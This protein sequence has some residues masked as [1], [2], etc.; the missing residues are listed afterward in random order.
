MEHA[1]KLDKQNI[2]DIL[3][4]TPLQEGMLFHYLSDPES[5]QYFEQLSLCLAGRIDRGLFRKAWDVV[6]GHNEM[7]RTVFRWEK[8]S[9][10]VQIV[11]KT[12]QIPLQELDFTTEDPVRIP[13]MLA[14]FREEDRRVKLDLAVAP[15]RLALCRLGAER[16][17]LLISSHHILYDGWSTG[18]ILKEFYNAY[19]EL[20]AQRPATRP[21]KCKFKTFLKKVQGQAPERQAEFWEKYLRGFNTRTALPAERIRNREISSVQKYA[22]TV[23][24]ELA[25]RIEPAAKE[26]GAT[27]ATVL[28]LAWGILLQRYNDIDDVVFG[29]TVALRDTSIPD[30]G[31]L[32]GLLINTPP[33]RVKSDPG[34]TI[35]CALQKLNRELQERSDF[36][37]TPLTLIKQ[38]TELSKQENLFDSIVVLDN[39]PLD[40]IF[41]RMDGEFK[42][43]SYSVFE[44][45]NFDL[46]LQIFCFGPLEICFN[47]NSDLFSVER[48]QRMGEHLQRALAA[49]CET[50]SALITGIEILSETE[51]HLLLYTFNDTRVEYP[52][53]RLIHQWVEIQAEAYPDRTAV[54]FEGQSLTYRALNAKANQVAALLKEH[55]IRPGEMVGLALPRSVE[56]IA[57][58][59]GILKANGICIPID[60]EH[61]QERIRTILEDCQAKAVLQLAGARALPG[62]AGAVL[63]FDLQSLGHYPEANQENHIQPESLAY[64][65]YTSG[66]TGKPKGAM[67]HHFGIVNHALTKIGVLGIT[68]RDTVGN[69][70][71]INVIAAIWQVLAPLFTGGKLVVYPEAVEK[72]PY[73]QFQR[74]AADQVSIIEV[75]P[76][77][78]NAYLRLLDGGQPRIPMPHLRK[79]ALTSEETKSALVRKFY[80]NYQIPL[81]DCY[82]QTECCDDTLH[83]EIPVDPETTVVPIG[84]PSRNTR[85]YVLSR[86]NQLQPIGIRGELCVSG[87]GVGAG[88]WQRPELTAEK[89]VPNPLEPGKMMYRTGDLA[90]WRPDG[91]MEYL[92]RIDHQV[93]IRGNR[94]ELGEI[95]SRLQKHPAIKEVAVALREDERKDPCLVAFLAASRELT[96]AELRA[97]LSRELPDYMIPVQFVR[98]EEMPLT[99][100]GKI[101]RKRL[102]Q[103]GQNIQIGVAYA[104]PE[105]EAQRKIAAIWREVLHKEKIGIHDHF[106]DLGGHS[107]LLIQ[108]R[109][110]LK[111]AFGKEISIVEMFQYPTVELLAGYFTSGGTGESLGDPQ[112]SRAVAPQKLSDSKKTS[113]GPEGVA[114]IG[115][116][117]YFPGARGLAEFWDN[118]EQGRESISFFTAEELEG[119]PALRSDPAYVAAGGVLEDAA[120]FDAGFFGFNPREAEMTDPQQRLF[121]KCA[122]EALEDAGY[123][124]ERPGGPV[125]VFAGVGAN[126]YLLNNL[127]TRRDLI[128]AAGEFQT[129]IGNDKDFLATRVSYKLNLKGPSVAVQTACST[130]LVAVHLARQSLLQGDCRMALAG[131]SY[132]RFPQ[133]SGYLYQEGG[134]LSP[135]GHCRT[136]DRDAKGTV[137]G[138]GVGVVVL[139]RLTDALQD[140]DHIY[141]VIKSSA[142]NNDG[143]QKVSYTA[144]GVDGQAEVIEKALDLAEIDPETISYI[145]AHGTATTLGDPI[146]VASLTKAFRRKTIK[147]GFCALGTVKTNIR[148]LDV[149]AGVAGLIKTALALK[150]RVLPPSL[151]FERLNPAIELLDS[152]FYI[153]NR[154]RNWDCQSPRRAGV[155]SFGIGGTNVHLILEEAPSQAGQDSSAEASK[156]ASGQLFL[157]SA[158]TEAA[159]DRMTANLAAALKKGPEGNLGASAQLA[160]LAYT[161]QMGRMEFPCRR[162]IFGRDREEVIGALENL[163]PQR[164]ASGKALIAKGNIAFLFT[165]DW[166]FDGEALAEIFTWEP[167]FRK[168]L[169]AIARLLKTKAGF[170]LIASLTVPPGAK[171][172]PSPVSPEMAGPVLLAIQYSLVQALRE[173]GITPH[174]ILGE[175][176]AE[177]TAACLAGVMPLELALELAGLQGEEATAAKLREVRLEAPKAPFFSNLTGALITDSEAMSP[178][179][180]AQRS[181]RKITIDSQLR[182][183]LLG[184]DF[185]VV[186]ITANLGLQVNKANKGAKP[187]R[188]VIQIM[189]SAEGLTQAPPWLQLMGK[190]WLRG[191]K[192]NWAAGFTG[193]KRHRVSAPS[194]PFEETPFWVDPLPQPSA[195]SWPGTGEVTAAGAALMKRKDPAAWFY[196]PGW[197][198]SD[199]PAFKPW[200]AGLAPGS[201]WLVFADPAGA[202]AGLVQQMVEILEEAGQKAILARPGKS[203]AHTGDAYSLNP[204]NPGDYQ[205]LFEDLAS[206]GQW[207]DHII[208][209]W[210]VTPPQAGEASPG[211]QYLGYYSLIFITRALA[212]QGRLDPL[213]ITVIANETA[214]VGG[215]ELLCPDKTTFLGAVKV[216]PQEHPQIFCRSIDIVLPKEDSQSRQLAEKLLKEAALKMEDSQIAYRGRRRWAMGF[217]NIPV[218]EAQLGPLKLKQGG[219]Y[220]ITGGLG[221]MGLAM[222]GY[223]AQAAQA[224]LIL[225]SRSG[226]P[227]RDQWSQWLSSHGEKD[228]A[229]D[230]IRKLQ[231]IEGFGA[232]VT[233]VKVDVAEAKPMRDLVGRI[234]SQ[235][236]AL[237]GVIHAAGVTGEQALHLVAETGVENSAVQ[238]RPKIQGL[239]VLEEALAGI[240]LDFCLLCS[241]LGG[242]LGG[243]GSSAYAAANIFMDNFARQQ[244][245]LGRGFYLSVDWDAWRFE[246]GKTKGVLEKFAMEPAEGIEVLERLLSWSGIPQIIVS[247]GF[248]PGRL[249]RNQGI[250][251]VQ[252][253]DREGA[254]RLRPAGE[255]KPQN[256]VEE[257]IAAVWEELLGVRLVSATQDFFELGGHSLLATQVISRLRSIFRM[258]LPIR[259]FFEAP[260]VQGL[261]RLIID[262]WGGLETALEVLAIYREL[263]SLTP[264]EARR[265]LEEG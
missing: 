233:V 84:R 215:E 123:D 167:S 92:G 128:R 23:S 61:P 47:Y 186:G 35:I 202:G 260:T 223:L 195:G 79:I 164:T 238:F 135:D 59:L 75:I 121:L 165:D 66:S 5:G 175:G 219:V 16:Y 157:L 42:I 126:S 211:L 77:V 232:E 37:A 141:A 87:D 89:F 220:L 242:I 206:A 227:A 196:L 29:T 106:F 160:D 45:T 100:N 144:P 247:T 166:D 225:T 102:P 33:L 192:I 62:T 213:D 199:L 13:Q 101:D 108:V 26:Y 146:E 34:E 230:A 38:H 154:R 264:E 173:W 158:K 256:P 72:D 168:H 248:L 15:M 90:R 259:Q 64:L 235:Y 27:L 40:Q 217:E 125:G 20:A 11:L 46:T 25:R 221:K 212:R 114:I 81:V 181:G 49:I 41:R 112:A 95:E 134:N 24:P 251:R 71:S 140:G 218:S 53:E 191:A 12:H 172:A 241:S 67:L 98:L 57:G 162:A 120:C 96:V 258:E 10:P 252:N 171:T 60:I 246:P 237:H 28:Y 6:T 52:K 105:T 113:G 187:K 231:E 122:W 240:E 155:S 82:G 236:G 205:A 107:L 239:K 210:N 119:D 226:F 201:G 94:I 99:P 197:K 169:E 50:P 156:T 177:Y 261:A 222:A 159:L 70:F 22:F 228:R 73:L 163:G 147:R 4:L 58:M 254:G 148:H 51:K 78:L 142:L 130:S 111:E 176:R 115:M 54:V 152:P 243:L 19:H 137:F 216:I 110:K 36:T 250:S 103:S 204:Q 97:F 68:D 43:E 244:H 14:K 188:P 234:I 185:L 44:M 118:L 104:A 209:M 56:M 17:E 86:H 253:Y 124:P 39:Y 149:A 245:Q 132:I 198:Q 8:L 93:K 3:G 18:I 117:G 178:D 76:S 189:D 139:K 262:H 214:E 182:T 174:L 74:V 263:A 229:S 190:L 65:I 170:D 138:N 257:Q 69:N 153:N 7:L 143:A 151:H 116:A 32:V 88:Y 136:F 129:I 80:R 55:G 194:Y 207:P 91:L 63:Y 48:I 183:R 249:E 21:P 30:I 83:Y 224:K 184:P 150:H 179:Y 208:H 31:N 200:R 1:I 265:R 109:S 2:E 193:E 161:L 145:E 133:K 85:V 180:W 9:K 127:I 255:F 203:F 131:G